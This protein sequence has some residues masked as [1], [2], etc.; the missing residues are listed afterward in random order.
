MR[1]PWFR[2]VWISFIPISLPGWLIFSGL[3][4]YAVYKFREIGSRSH[5]ASDTLI[6]FAFYLVII[7]VVYNLIAYFTGRAKNR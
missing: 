4:V 3:V 7:G 5:S 2:R 1:L 6:N